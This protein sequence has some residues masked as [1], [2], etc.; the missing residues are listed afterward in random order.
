MRLTVQIQGVRLVPDSII[1][2]TKNPDISIIVDE[3]EKEAVDMF[4]MA[5]N[6]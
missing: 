6:A 1:I 4:V 3:K 5:M 2:K